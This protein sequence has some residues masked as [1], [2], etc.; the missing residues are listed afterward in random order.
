VTRVGRNRWIAI[1]AVVVVAIVAAGYG[2]FAAF[3]GGGPAA[4]SLSPGATADCTPTTSGSTNASSGS[5]D[6]TWKVSSASD[7]F[8]GYR[9]REQL[10]ILPAPSDAVGRTTAV[11]GQLEVSG[12]QITAVD[13]TADMTQLTS[14]KS[15]RD[16][17]LRIM[18]LG[19]DAFP[20]A[21]FV[22]TSPIEFASQP[23][24]G[25][26]VS[27]AAEGTLTLHGVTRA[28]CVPV[29]AS[30]TK[31]AIQVLGSTTINFS[32]YQIEHRTPGSSRCRITERWGSS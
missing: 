18:G 31:G 32:D 29:Q 21:E 12:L 22:L 10:S 7:S 6:G 26:T 8:V 17:R 3:A 4:V 25:K 16:E 1:A 28:I 5:L 13:V 11:D 27:A 30:W 9:V 20:Q 23:P 2:V 24:K 15:M 14:D 19:T